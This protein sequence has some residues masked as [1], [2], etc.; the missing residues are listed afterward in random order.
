MDGLQKRVEGVRDD[1]LRVSSCEHQQAWMLNAK[2][3]YRSMQIASHF[4]ARVQGDSLRT[5]TFRFLYAF[6]QVFF[7]PNDLTYPNFPSYLG[8]FHTA[9]SQRETHDCCGT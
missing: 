9:T 8:H 1:D 6:L 5:G 4:T 7:F 2:G 3:T